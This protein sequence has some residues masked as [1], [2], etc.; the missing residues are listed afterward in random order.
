MIKSL[1][2]LGIRQN[3]YIPIK[4]N[5]DYNKKILKNLNNINFI[6]SK[7]FNNFDRIYYFRK[8]NKILNDI[9]NKVDL[10]N[11]NI[12]HAHTLFSMGGIA[13][14]LKREKNIDYVVSVRN[15]DVN[16][17]FKNIFYLRRIGIQIMKE[18]KKIV[19]ESYTWSNNTQRL[20]K[21]Y[22]ETI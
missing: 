17:F 1:D 10:N 13:L 22:N 6:Y 16:V 7:T 15:S 4:K 21:I 8:I 18:A 9:K 11:I 12:I 20:I 2:K 19:C 5:Q 3:V 14:K